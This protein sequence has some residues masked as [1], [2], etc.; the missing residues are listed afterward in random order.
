MDGNK[1]TVAAVVVDAAATLRATGVGRYF[2]AV[3]LG[4][5]LVGWAIGEVVAVGLLLAIIVVPV[6]RRGG[7]DLP[8][9][10]ESWSTAGPPIAIFL[11][12][13]LWTTL[14]TIGGFAAM[15]AFLRSVAGKDRVRLLPTGLELMRSAGPFKR[16][17]VVDRVDI[18][19]IRIRHHDHALVADTTSGTLILTD[20]GTRPER[21][22]ICQWLRGGLQLPLAGVIR[23]DPDKAPPG[24]KM[25]TAEDGS[26]RLRRRGAW[27]P[28]LRSEWLVRRG[29]VT[30]RRRI[31]PWSSERTYDHAQFAIEHTTDSDGDD[32]YR[33]I[34]RAAGGTRT[35]QSAIN[36]DGEIVDC[37]RWLAARTGFELQL[38]R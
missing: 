23:I 31:G 7:A 33:L 34:L 21:E 1:G 35:L 24:W 2:G 37:G 6:L 16:T 9:F 13:M 11:F 25:E 12:L 4:L 20:L 26:V 29:R 3:F 14:W 19:R 17:R 30:H 38:W 8:A 27:L 36:D 15:T 5:W 22:T 32:L 18:H 28:W 10:F